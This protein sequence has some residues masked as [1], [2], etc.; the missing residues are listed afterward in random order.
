L[1]HTQ[2]KPDRRARPHSNPFLNRETLAFVAGRP[3]AW[4]AVVDAAVAEARDSD[5]AWAGAGVEAAAAAVVEV[6]G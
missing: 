1:W 3:V 6:A 4:G 2:R 5:P